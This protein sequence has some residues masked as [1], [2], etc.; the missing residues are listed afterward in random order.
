MIEKIDIILAQRNERADR[1]GT[2]DG[3]NT[4]AIFG[5]DTHDMH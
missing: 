1:Q 2:G 3:T 5:I 4:L